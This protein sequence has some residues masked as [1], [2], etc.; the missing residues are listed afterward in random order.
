MLLTDHRH[1]LASVTVDLAVILS[2]R[3]MVSSMKNFCCT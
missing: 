2:V 3:V 1:P